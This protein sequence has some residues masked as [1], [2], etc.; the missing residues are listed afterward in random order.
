MDA[1]KGQ[2]ETLKLKAEEMIREYIIAQNVDFVAD[3][4]AQG[5]M[6]ESV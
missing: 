3:K 6:G 4:G 5:K 2:M 1:T